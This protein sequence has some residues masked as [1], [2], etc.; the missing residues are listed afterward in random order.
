MNGQLAYEKV[1][2]IISHE[3]NANQ[4]HKIPTVRF[5]VPMRMGIIKNQI[6]TNTGLDV[7]KLD[8]LHTA[9]GNV[10]CGTTK[11]MQKM[12]SFSNSSTESYYKTQKY[13]S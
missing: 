2:D 1:L 13:H 5:S 4:N 7:E 3:E 9:S 10:R 8:P 12:A 11:M 6:I